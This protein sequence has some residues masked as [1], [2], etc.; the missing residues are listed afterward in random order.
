MRE[1]LEQ[2]IGDTKKN[3]DYFFDHLNKDTFESIFN[4]ICNLEGV[5]FVTG[6]GKSGIIAK[7]IAVT[8][9]SS[10]TK[11]IFLSAQ[12]ALHGDI[13]LISKGDLVLILSKSGESD[14]LVQLCPALRN[15]GAE[16][17]A[18]VSNEK[19]RLVRA[20]EHTIVLPIA[21]ELCP[22]NMVPTI[23]TQAQLIFGD[24]LAV[25]MMKKKSFTLDEY[26]LNHPAGRIGKRLIVRVKDLM[27]QRPQLPLCKK[28]DKLIDVLSEFS[29]K[30]C[31]CLIVVDEKMQMEGLFTDGD[32]RRSLE[33]HKNDL[34][35]QTM[36]ELMTKNPRSIPS[37]ALAFK[38]VEM[39][40]ED[41]KRPI[42]LLPVV[43]E[44]AIVGLLRMHDI[45]Q[46]G[47]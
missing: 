1:T 30:K 28:E 6:I 36:N 19:S 22:F 16:L 43:D 21:Q 7:K 47:I 10:G 12:D 27:V 23:S 32:L 15:K 20:C 38:A 3:L 45:I 37:S 11:A 24:L 5:L 8:L 39:M 31:G 42:Y 17:V 26:A 13:G 29:S 33:K 35:S 9:S 18:V 41:Q 46:S 4:L 44:G 14:E 34:F 40:E 2:L 25:G